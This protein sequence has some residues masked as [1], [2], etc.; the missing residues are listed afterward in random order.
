VPKTAKL[1]IN[2]PS[3]IVDKIAFEQKDSISITIPQRLL[4]KTLTVPSLTLI[5]TGMKVRLLF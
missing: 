2:N 1:D 5:I 3:Q 4:E